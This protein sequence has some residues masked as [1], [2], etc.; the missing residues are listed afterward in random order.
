MNT[1]YCFENRS[2][3]FV[4][5]FRQTAERNGFKVVL[6]APDA[7]DADFMRFREVYQH[8]SVNPEGFELA[9]FHRYFAMRSLLSLGERAIMAD[10]DLFIQCA[11]ESIPA[12]LTANPD[13]FVGSIGIADGVSEEDIS[14]HFSFWT[15][16]LL[17]D[18]C[19]FMIEQYVGNVERLREIYTHRCQKTSRASVSDMTLLYL[20]VQDRKIA[21]TN[22]NQLFGARYIDHNVSSTD[23]AN[24]RFETSFG[25]K[26]ML[27]GAD[28]VR[29]RTIDGKTVEPLALHLQGRYKLAAMPLLTGN[30]VKLWQ[31]SAYIAG[32]RIARQAMSRLR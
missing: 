28:G 12:E 16:A 31:G 29:L 20:W 14:P 27:L 2:A 22:S 26:K 10:S 15:R 17:D 6:Q 8:L 1:L 3:P 13:G 25:R 7:N 5:V 4:D 23:C 32:G 24:A 11:P 18:F 19:D 30:R 9:C 21:F